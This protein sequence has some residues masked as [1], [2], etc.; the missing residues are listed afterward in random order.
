MADTYEIREALKDE[1]ECHG[2]YLEVKQSRR[3]P[4]II[5]SLHRFIHHNATNLEERVEDVV[6]EH[7]DLDVEIEVFGT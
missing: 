5:V 1:L 2:A 6:A 4:R 7:T 3:D